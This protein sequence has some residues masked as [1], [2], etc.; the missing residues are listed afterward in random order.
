MK[1]EMRENRHLWVQFDPTK[2]DFREVII[3]KENDVRINDGQTVVKVRL[4][5][6]KIKDVLVDDVFVWTGSTDE[7]RSAKR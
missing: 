2:G 1:V 5:G 3:D 6:K 7:A 4:E